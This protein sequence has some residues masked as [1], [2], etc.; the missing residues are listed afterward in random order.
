MY[1]QYPGTNNLDFLKISA[2]FELLAYNAF[3]T[4]TPKYQEIPGM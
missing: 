4:K 2:L 1:A 3:Y